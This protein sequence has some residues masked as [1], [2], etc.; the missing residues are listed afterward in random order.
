[1]KK[2]LALVLA[3]C[4][5]LALL[6]GCGNSNTPAASGSASG[7][8]ATGSVYYLNFKPESD[9]AW[10]D[11]AKQYTEETGVPV[12]VVTAASGKYNDTLTVEMDKAEAPT[13][14]QCGNAGA[15]KT[16]GEFC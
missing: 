2:T 7:T 10:Q 3:A 16:W 12:K 15:I 1:M 11:L 9:Q 13:M 6:A 4:L 8:E 5:C 14:F